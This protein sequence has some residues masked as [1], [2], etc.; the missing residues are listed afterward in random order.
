MWLF[1][2]KIYNYEVN[3][4]SDWEI[5]DIFE[6][7]CI[8]SW[9]YDCIIKKE[10]LSDKQIQRLLINRAVMLKYKDN[11]VI[12]SVSCKLKTGDNLV[13]CWNTWSW[14][15]YFYSLLDK[16]WLVEKLYDED[17]IGIDK[18][19]VIFS[20]AKA[21]FK[22]KVN[23]WYNYEYDEPDFWKVDLFV[24]MWDDSGETYNRGLLINSIVH[25]LYK[26]DDE[27]LEHYNRFPE[28]NDV[29]SFYIPSIKNKNRENFIYS[30]IEDIWI[31]EKKS[32]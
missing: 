26:A 29:R 4:Y 19:W 11:W 6:K 23:W 13:I 28:F 27:M 24:I 15:S 5:S 16:K 32:F 2:V 14:K 7:K 25:N 22:G 10:Y 18:D 21:N 20:L 31:R 9:D 1:R 3:V 8:N 12:H 17:L 30:V